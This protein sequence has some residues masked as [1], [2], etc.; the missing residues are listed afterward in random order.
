M[1]HA[2]PPLRLFSGQTHHLY[3]ESGTALVVWHGVVTVT[4]AP[5]W[6]GGSVWR[7]RV[8]VEEGQA[9]AVE[10]SGWFQLHCEKGSAELVCTTRQTAPVP[11][12]F[13]TTLLGF[14]R[15]AFA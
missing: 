6:L 2:P 13:T 4:A 5:S 11:A 3:L 12:R 15:R 8:S 9:H 1:T 14:A 7:N 10:S